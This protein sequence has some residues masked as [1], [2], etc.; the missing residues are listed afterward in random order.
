LQPNDTRHFQQGIVF[1]LQQYSKALQ[2]TNVSVRRLGSQLPVVLVVVLAGS[3]IDGE[4]LAVQL[5]SDVAAGLLPTL[6]GYG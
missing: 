1:Y 2:I 3:E 4:G 5:S 6:T